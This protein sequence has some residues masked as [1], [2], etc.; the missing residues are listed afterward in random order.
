MQTPPAVS[1]VASSS[2]A[3]QPAPPP[4]AFARARAGPSDVF[5]P[6]FP[7]DPFANTAT[8]DASAPPWIIDADRLPTLDDGARSDVIFVL[9]RK[10]CPA[11]VAPLRFFPGLTNVIP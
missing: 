3:R 4:T 11:T 7:L 6:R 9:S 2:R 10:C 1:P 5:R 8:L